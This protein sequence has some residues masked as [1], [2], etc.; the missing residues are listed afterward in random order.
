MSCYTCC[1]T[2]DTSHIFTVEVL[3]V[4]N[5]LGSGL[6]Q[7]SG[8]LGASYIYKVKT[9]HCNGEVVELAT[10][11]AQWQLQGHHEQVFI[12]T[13]NG[14]PC[15]C[16][17]SVVRGGEEASEGF[18]NVDLVLGHVRLFPFVTDSIH[19]F[20]IQVKLFLHLF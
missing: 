3:P 7:A 1:F 10:C 5:N 8:N 20:S 17:Q 18:D 4:M 12:N 19:E 2:E 13:L 9:I 6:T 11:Y 15:E 14:A 16:T